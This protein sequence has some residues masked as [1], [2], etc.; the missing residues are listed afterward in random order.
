VQ[1]DWERRYKLIRLHTALHVISC[2]VIATVT[3]GNISPDK[4]RLD[5][6]IDMSLLLAETIEKGQ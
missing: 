1:L 4:A 5:F 3:G 2:V 6:D